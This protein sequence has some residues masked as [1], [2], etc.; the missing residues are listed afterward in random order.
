MSHPW[1]HPHARLEQPR[2]RADIGYGVPRLG[3]RRCPQLEL[4][5]ELRPEDL[6][7]LCR[8]RL[9]QCGRHQ[10]RFAARSAACA[11]RSTGTGRK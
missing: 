9:T 8:G 11:R 2:R 3:D 10:A 6:R 4:V 1:A 7:V 5:L